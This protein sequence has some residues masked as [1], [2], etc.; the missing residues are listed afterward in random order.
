MAE[1]YFDPTEL[2][3]GRVVWNVLESNFR[4]EDEEF[5]WSVLFL[6]YPNGCALDVMWYGAESNHSV[7]FYI[8]LVHADG[9]WEPCKEEYVP[10]I[11]E[12]R[13]A[14]RR[15]AAEAANRPSIRRHLSSDWDLPSPFHEPPVDDLV[16]DALAP[17]ESQL[18]ALKAQ[19]FV[20]LWG[21]TDNV[22][23]SWDPPH[24]YPGSFVVRT[25]D[26]D[27]ERLDSVAAEEDEG[28]PPRWWRL[29]GEWRC[30]SV[31]ELKRHVEALDAA[32]R[33]KGR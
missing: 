7:G 22:V 14:V 12:L 1:L 30:Q 16:L 6:R 18:D 11:E 21:Y 13:P 2:S 32:R 19:L 25:Y 8:T 27:W 28:Y 20:G 4:P 31:D 17:L 33:L 3:G 23:I 24:R 5:D 26:T 29:T 15:L 10:R 9:V